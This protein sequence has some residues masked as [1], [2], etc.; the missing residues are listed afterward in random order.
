M[1][2][3]SSF[4]YFLHYEGRDINRI[5]P[6]VIPFYHLTFVM[7]GS[8]TYFVDGEKIVLEPNDALL[9]VPGT[10]RERVYNPDNVHFV[11]FN[12]TPL[13]GTE[14]KASILF[15]N[16]VNQTIRK[17][18]DAYPY[19]T[20]LDPRALGVTSPENEKI[21]TVV[22]NIFNCILIEL[23][24]SLKYNTDNTHMLAALK[25]IN[26]NLTQ[27][28]TLGCVS[29]ELHLSREHTAR[30][31]KKEMGMTATDY[32]N[33]QKLALAKSMLTNPE[34]SMQEIAAKLGY[35]NYCY[36]S[37]IFKKEFGISPLAMK[38][39]LTKGE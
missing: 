10:H 3:I 24:D 18:L 4:S 19:N 5:E 8:F 11:L 34:M 13:P 2:R 22:R 25:Y 27:P 14:P 36:F 16:A 12:Y 7:D 35:V 21:C 29:R 1:D 32:I 15:K 28:L 23:F 38:S 30:L 17:L 37:K 20:H 6:N 33:G 39:R 9:L 26:E 31:F